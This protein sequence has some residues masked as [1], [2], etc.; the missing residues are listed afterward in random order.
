MPKIC[1]FNFAFSNCCFPCWTFWIYQSCFSVN[2]ATTSSWSSSVKF[3]NFLNSWHTYKVGYTPDFI[4]QAIVSIIARRTNVILWNFSFGNPPTVV[5]ASNILLI[6][7]L[8]L[9]YLVRRNKGVFSISWN[10]ISMKLLIF[11]ISLCLYLGYFG[12]HR[13]WKDVFI[14]SPFCAKLFLAWRSYLYSYT[15]PFHRSCSTYLSLGFQCSDTC[16]FWRIRFRTATC[17][18]ESDRGWLT[19]L[20]GHPFPRCA[21]LP[22]Y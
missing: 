5:S 14:P 6:V 11:P 16:S 7:M 21:R 17:W 19:N 10:M 9:A 1:F 3:Y 18:S 8:T 13:N 20:S 12:N 4:S 2:K 22:P 15:C